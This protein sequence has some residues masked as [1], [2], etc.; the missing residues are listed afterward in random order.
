MAF[1]IQADNSGVGLYNV[2]KSRD[3]LKFSVKMFGRKKYISMPQTLTG[4]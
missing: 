4:R 1:C 2:S 3:V